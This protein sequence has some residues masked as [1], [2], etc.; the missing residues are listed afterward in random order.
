MKAFAGFP[1][2]GGFWGGAFGSTRMIFAE[3]EEEGEEIGRIEWPET[4]LTLVNLSGLERAIEE[5]EG[6]GKE[7]LF[8]SEEGWSS[9]EKG[10]WE[11]VGLKVAKE[12]LDWVASKNWEMLCSWRK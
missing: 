3:N 6:Y 7:T 11:E 8:F 1:E 12:L 9:E 2:G 5:G 4:R 10:G